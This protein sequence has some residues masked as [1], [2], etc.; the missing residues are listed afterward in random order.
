ME[1]NEMKGR[2]REG[3]RGVGDGRVEGRKV[4]EESEGEKGEGKEEQMK[5][6]NWRD[7]RDH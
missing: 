5:V 4:V 7:A 6:Q 1:V 2:G 3:G